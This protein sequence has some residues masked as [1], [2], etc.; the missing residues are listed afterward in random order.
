VYIYIN[1]LIQT[2]L[3]TLS[4]TVHSNY[5]SRPTKTAKLW[6][7]C[8]CSRCS[9]PN[10]KIRRDHL[11]SLWQTVKAAYDICSDCIIAAGESAADTKS[12]LRSKYYQTYSTYEIFAAQLMEQ[13]QK[14]S[15]QIPQA[16]VIPSQ[17]STSYGCR[18]PPI[19]TEVFSGDY[20]RWPTFRDLFTA[21][22]I[23]NPSLTPVKNY[24]I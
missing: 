3:T 10:N 7:H 11:N 18:L 1:I 21:I 15:S 14:G 6:S 5:F 19:D 4:N 22:Y 13:I 9:Y 8:E 17:N 2:S 16:P 12:V 24:L 23:D 20:L